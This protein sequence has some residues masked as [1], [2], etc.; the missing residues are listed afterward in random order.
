MFDEITLQRLEQTG[1]K[2]RVRSDTTSSK[3]VSLDQ[4]LKEHYCHLSLKFELIFADDTCLCAE[5]E[6]HLQSAVYTHIFLKYAYG[7]V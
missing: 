6:V 1:I 4:K 2:L 5:N 7:L 3:F